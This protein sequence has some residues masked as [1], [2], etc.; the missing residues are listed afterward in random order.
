MKA[1]LFALCLALPVVLTLHGCAS[2]PATPDWEMNAQGAMDRSVEAY[3]S[4]NAR[5]DA[6][7]LARAR[8]EIS[9]TGRID[10]LARAELVHCAARVASLVFTP[11]AAFEALRQD[12]PPAERAYAN[13]L[14]GRALAADAPLLPESQRGVATT[15]PS[16]DGSRLKAI[17]DPLS[18]LVAAGVLLQT[19]NANPAVISLAIDTASAQGWRRPLMAWLLLQAQRAEQAGD[20]EEAERLRRRAA[21]VDSGGTD[22]PR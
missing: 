2:G 20:R 8:S 18:R 16:E 5:V 15:G 11:C 12:A 17:A 4:G 1:R 6:L 19:G 7:E 10:L 3:L 9:R 13:Y 22:K 21:L 14:A